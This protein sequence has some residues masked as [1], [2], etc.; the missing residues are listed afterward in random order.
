ML[1]WQASRCNA[2]SPAPPPRRAFFEKALDTLTQTAVSIEHPRYHEPSSGLPLAPQ[3][4][5]VY[6]NPFNRVQPRSAP[7]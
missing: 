6:P 3:L 2:S 4:V 5:G 1:A 7:C